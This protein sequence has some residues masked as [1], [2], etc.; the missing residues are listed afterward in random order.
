MNYTAMTRQG[1]QE[2]TDVFQD[3]QEISGIQMP[4]TTVTYQGGSEAATTTLDNVTINA[5][6]ESGLF[7]TSDSSGSSE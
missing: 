4:Q 1:P 6:L 7:Q 2:S 3:Y 5:D